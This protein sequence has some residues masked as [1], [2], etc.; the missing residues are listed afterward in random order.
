[1][2]VQLNRSMSLDTI[3]IAKNILCDA[4]INSTI[5]VER[6]SVLSG[7]ATKLMSQTV[8]RKVGFDSWIAENQ[9]PDFV[10]THHYAHDKPKNVFL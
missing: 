7:N 2:S 6:H 8:L 10:P 5:C 1:M 9:G 3:S 4:P